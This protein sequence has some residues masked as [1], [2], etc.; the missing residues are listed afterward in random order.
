MSTKSSFLKLL[1]EHAG[2]YVSGEKVGELLGVSRTAVSKACAA[3]R[4]DGY[5]IDSRTNKG[6]M[7]RGSGNLLTEDGISVFIRVPCDIEVFDVTD[8][9]N[10]QAKKRPAGKLPLVLIADKQTAGKGRLGRRFES[11]AGSG[12]YMTFAFRPDFDI[13]NS[14]FVTMAVAVGTCRAIEKVTGRKAGIK[15]VNDLFTDGKKICGI[16]TEAQSDFETGTIDKLITGIGV[17]CFPGSFPPEIAHIA[18]AL[19]EEQGSFSREELAAEMINEILPLITA[20]VFD[21]F[22]DEY[23]DRCFILGSEIKIHPT[24][25]DSGIRAKAVDIA[26]DGGLVVE[27]LEDPKAADLLGLTGTAADIFRKAKAGA[28]EVLH[29]GEISVSF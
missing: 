21:A 10:E 23:R 13:S 27:Y 17:N 3:L 1:S 11:P 5:L 19:A 15:W 2:E 28:K 25:N 6:Y 4:N 14:L 12:L 29:T 20:P 26:D 9:T 22:I 24:Y 8:S 16:L 7:L 18:G